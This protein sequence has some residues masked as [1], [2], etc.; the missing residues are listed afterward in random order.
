TS[1]DVV[2][3]ARRA[4]GVSRI[5]H[6]GTLD[7]MATGVLP[8]V[9]G[10]ATRLAQF[11][12][13]SDK[14]YDATVAFGRTTDTYDATGKE[15]ERCDRRP[16][17]EALEKALANFRGVFEQTPPAYSAKSIDGERSY[18]LARK[19]A[20]TGGAAGSPSPTRPKA[21]AV[22]VTRL[23]ILSF[24]GDTATLVLQVSAGFYV[25]SLAHDLG[26]VLGCGAVLS[27]LRRT[28]S[29]EFGLE[30]AVPLAEVLQSPRASLAA[31][32]VPL[33]ALLI[34][35]PAVALRSDKQL[36]RLKNGVEM[37]PADLV[38]P[39]VTMPPIVR[40]LGPDGDLVGLAKPG[41]TLGFLHGWVVLG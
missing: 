30:H 14:T 13:A 37:G 21:V 3:I 8:L 5:G 20:R 36:E 27:A 18:E 17:R 7:P 32:L 1:H 11:L 19:S 23:E 38:E 16:T 34:G 40:L 41:K 31:R 25:R 28:R 26:E 22:T 6:T 24:D 35:V 2:T 10:R 29:G 12:T 9:V 15:I 4:L 39:L 33:R